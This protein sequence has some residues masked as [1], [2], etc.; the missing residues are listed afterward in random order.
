V[1]QD[2]ICDEAVGVMD[3]EQLPQPELMTSQQPEL[4]TTQPEFVTP[5]TSANA[6]TLSASCSKLTSRKRRQSDL[7]AQYSKSM[8]SLQ[9]VIK[10]RTE[11]QKAAI[12]D[13]E[14][15]IFGKFVACECR[16]IRNSKIKRQLKK[17]FHDLLYEATEEDDASTEHV[18][19]Y[20]VLQPNETLSEQ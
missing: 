12:P 11:N 2:E 4:M 17:K 13:D 1:C 20:I 18:L 15:D 16:K 10:S 5:S 3:D 7:D 6:S 19:Q 9:Q 14:D 8:E